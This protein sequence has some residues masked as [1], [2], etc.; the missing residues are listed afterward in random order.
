M[1]SQPMHMF[2]FCGEREGTTERNLIGSSTG[3]EFV[4]DVRL[5]LG[6]SFVLE[7]YIINTTQYT[8]RRTSIPLCEPERPCDRR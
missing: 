2:Q 7:P 1:L 8:S 3:N 4:S 6:A 5:V